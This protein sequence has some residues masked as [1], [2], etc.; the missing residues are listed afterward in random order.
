MNKEK[1]AYSDHHSPRR[2]R[3]RDHLGFFRLLNLSLEHQTVFTMRIYPNLNQPEL[4][5]L[6]TSTRL[7]ARVFRQHVKKWLWILDWTLAG[8]LAA[9][10]HPNLKEEHTACRE[11]V[12]EASML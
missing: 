11:D 5:F 4:T 6:L 12:V 3:Q 8:A 10:L 1:Y 9:S 7:A 2:S